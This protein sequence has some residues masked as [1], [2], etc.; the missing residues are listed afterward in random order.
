MTAD[1]DVKQQATDAMAALLSTT[2]RRAL[3][4]TFD[5]HNPTVSVAERSR[6][7]AVGVGFAVEPIS[8]ANN[9][10]IEV[11][12]GVNIK[13]RPS[14]ESRLLIIAD[15]TDL[16]Q[17]LDV[18]FPNEGKRHAFVH[19]TDLDISLRV[20][21]VDDESLTYMIGGAGDDSTAL[22]PQRTIYQG[23][24]VITAITA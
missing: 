15:A 8:E 24:N 20:T 6:T 11:Y 12:A 1:V 14:T 4:I 16:T 5:W 9:S 2:G 21:G 19:H 7:V 22:R 13:D 18:L 10:V 17:L 23:G 3:E